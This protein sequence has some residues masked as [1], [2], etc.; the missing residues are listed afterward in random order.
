[1]RLSLRI[2]VES[3]AGAREGVPALLR[4]LDQ[5]QVKASFLLSLGPDFSR[6]PLGNRLPSW[7]MGRL[8]VTYTGKRNRATLR[9]IAEAGHEVGITAYS[10]VAWNDQVAFRSG[11]WTRQQL[12]SAATA[13][14]ELYGSRPCYF[15]A[16]GWQVNPH[17]L[18]EEQ[19]LGLHFASDVRGQHPF[20]PELQGI[21]SD[22]PQIPVTLPTLDE[23]HYM[24]GVNSANLHQYLFAACQR[25]L[26]MGE[27]FSLSAEREGRDLLPVFERLLVMWKGSQWE[28]RPLG[29]LYQQLKAISLGRHRIGWGEVEG[30]EGHIAMQSVQLDG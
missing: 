22:C 12:A 26:P 20:L 5:Y 30:R 13:F 2:E 11:E 15:G 16:T 27:V 8:P 28:I 29:E 21:R 19:A 23:L 3:D 4:L 14:E 7:L 10:S 24:K 9:A 17:L 18:T 6:Y 25:V 1:M